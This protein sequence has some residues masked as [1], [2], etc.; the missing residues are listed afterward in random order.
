MSSL[1]RPSAE[2]AD[3][4]VTDGQAVLVDVRERQEWNAGHAPGVLH[5]PLTRLMAG[6]PLAA[7]AQGMAAWA[8][9]GL[10]VTGVNGSGGVIA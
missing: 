5:L 7:T 8:R 4:L 6:G 10:P 9:P 2:Q 3:L 1:F